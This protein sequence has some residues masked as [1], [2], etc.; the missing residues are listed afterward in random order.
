MLFVP[1]QQTLEAQVCM[2]DTLVLC[3]CPQIVNTAMMMIIIVVVIR[4]TNTVTITNTTS[5]IVTLYCC[6][7]LLSG[8]WA[9]YD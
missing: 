2:L 9:A 1:Y 5:A 4:T 7:Y 3:T 8:C 6:E